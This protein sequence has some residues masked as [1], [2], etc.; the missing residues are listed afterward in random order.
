MTDE[1]VI[2]PNHDPLLRQIRREFSQQRIAKAGA[3]AKLQR[4]FENQR[5]DRIRRNELTRQ[6]AI[7]ALVRTYRRE[8]DEKFRGS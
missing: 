8:L 7:D 2:I 4:E 3:E 6:R 5:R 1:Y